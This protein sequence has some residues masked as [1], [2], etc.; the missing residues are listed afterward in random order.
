M[1]LA[2]IVLFCYCSVVNAQSGRTIR[3]QVFDAV[4]GAPLSELRLTLLTP[5][6]KPAADLLSPDE[7]GRFVFNGIPPGNYFLT[8]ELSDGT[9][10]LYGQLPDDQARM[11]AVPTENDPDPVLFR[12]QP[13]A[14]ISGL[15]QDETGEPLPNALVTANRTMWQ[16]IAPARVSIA[17]SSTDD[18]G[19]YSLE[20]PA[21]SYVICAQPEGTP[22]PV[23]SV[24]YVDF[25]ALPVPAFFQGAC[26]PDENAFPVRPGQ[27]LTVDLTL[28][29]G[30]D[31]LL[32]GRLTGEEHAIVLLHPVGA[33]AGSSFNHP[34]LNQAID[35]RQN[36]LVPHVPA[37]EYI[38]DARSDTGFARIPLSVAG[39]FV[40]VELAMRPLA[41]I[42]VAFHSPRGKTLAN[43]ISPLGLIP[44]TG[45]RRTI[46]AQKQSDGSQHFDPLPP[47][48]YW[49]Q[50]RSSNNTCIV[51]VTLNNRN[52]LHRLLRIETGARLQ[53]DLT[54]SDQCGAIDVQVDASVTPFPVTRLVVLLSGTPDAPGDPWTDILLGNQ[55][56][57]TLLPAG[58][59][60]LWAWPDDYFSPY[61]GPRSLQSVAKY[62]TAIDLHEGERAKVRIPLLGL[63]GEFR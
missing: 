25:A 9:V 34:V 6:G 26:Q 38:I 41:A 33:A 58:H 19:R 61:N 22:R 16:D 44:A 27:Q 20:L 5:Q 45:E 48:D 23:P 7:N 10:S 59:Y 51:A 39:E 4:S 55:Y 62:A 32:R 40:D 24:G 11:I 29:P 35:A 21:G 63:A 28:P 43:D 37:G 36:F 31:S 17:T 50:T 12:I 60:L 49:L 14:L 1:W 18:R 57:I 13:R 53:L 54:L 52:V 15:V 8:A 46:F 56:D 2:A 30:P 42:E 3:G 47:G